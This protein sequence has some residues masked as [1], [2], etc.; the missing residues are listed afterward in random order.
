MEIEHDSKKMRY[1]DF[2]AVLTRGQC[3]CYVS[4][5]QTQLLSLFRLLW[6]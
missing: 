6:K 4:H 1:F 5:I 2:K 3:F